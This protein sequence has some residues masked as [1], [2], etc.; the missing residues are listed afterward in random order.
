MQLVVMPNVAIG[1]SFLFWGA[2]PQPAEAIG[3]TD[4]VLVER[5]LA[6][7]TIKNQPGGCR[8]RRAAPGALAG[9]AVRSWWRQCCNPTRTG[10][11]AVQFGQF[12]NN[13]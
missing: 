5:R 1:L 13:Q 12:A 2:P 3:I 6:V 10:A 9:T 11:T 7:T 4:R 8:D